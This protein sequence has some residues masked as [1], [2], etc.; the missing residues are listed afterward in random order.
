M[1]K[2]PDYKKADIPFTERNNRIITLSIVL[3]V[4]VLGFMVVKNLKDK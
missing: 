2:N 3:I 4:A 1:I